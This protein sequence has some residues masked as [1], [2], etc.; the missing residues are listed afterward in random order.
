[1]R[2]DREP[3]R[4]QRLPEEIVLP[5]GRELLAERERDLGRPVG[6]QHLDHLGS[7][8]MCSSASLGLIGPAKSGFVA[9]TWPNRSSS[10]GPRRLAFG[11]VAPT[12][13]VCPA[14]DTVCSGLIR[15]ASQIAPAATTA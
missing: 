5:A 14:A 11:S 7:I 12:W 10:P 6:A 1:E 2:N 3:D 9:I 13:A 4:D 8:V 15:S